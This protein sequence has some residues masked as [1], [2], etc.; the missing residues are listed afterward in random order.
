[1]RTVLRLLLWITA[2]VV[3]IVATG[4]WWFVYRPLPQLDGSAVVPGLHGEVTVERD[5]WGVPHIRA[6]S[7]EDL[8]EAQG[9]VLAQDRLWQMDLL[10]RAAR[11]QLS[12]V[13][14]PATLRIDKDFRLLNFSRAA[15]RDFGMVSPEVRRVMEAYARGVNLY[16]EEHTTR[17]PIEFT[18][19]NYKP[20]PWQPTDSLVIACYMYRTLTDTREEEMG[21]AIV[22]AKVGPELAKDLYSPEASMDHFVVGEANAGKDPHAAV[23]SKR[24]QDDDDEEMDPEDVLKASKESETVAPD[25]TAALGEEVKDWL[26]ESQ[27][28]IRHSLGSNNW[29]V[30]GEHTATGKPILAND[31][32]LEL[33]LPPIWYEVHLTAPDWNVKGFALP[34]APM[35]VVGHND[36]IAWGFTNNGADVLDLYIETFNPENPDEYRVN[37]AWKKADVYDEVIKVKGAADEHLK[38]VVTR[39]GP[40]VHQDGDKSYAM[41]WTVLEPGALCNFYNW[42][43]KAQNWGEFRETMKGIWGPGQNVVYA[44][45]DGN[46]GYVL[47]AHVP[48]RKKGHGEVPVPGDTDDYEWTGYIPFDQLPQAF[49][50]ESGLIVTANARVTGPNYKPYITD[51]WEEPYRTARIYD[52]LHDKRDLRPEDMLKIQVDTY[53]YP[54][55]FLGEQLVA[56]AKL[57][58]PK[59]ERAR[60]LI[61]QAKDWNGMAD[62]NSPVVSF[63]DAALFRALDLI[64]EPQLG[65]DTEDY[66]W[67][68]VAFLQRV[69]TERPARWLPADYKNY[70]ELLSAA[71]DQAVKRLEQKTK[72][73]DPDDWAWKRFNYLD[74][75][76]PIGRDG[77][78]KRLLSI[79][80]QPQ[81]GTEWSPRAASRHHGPSERFVANLADWDESIMLITGGES[82]QTGS[83]HYRDQFPYWFDGK[84][85]YEPFSDAAEAKARRH[86]LTLKPGS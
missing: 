81:S 12:E 35:V 68:R 42:L 78:L 13:L 65:K 26:E 29:V 73:A 9:Y 45:V 66:H 19:L 17:L 38:L 27:R 56:A 69:L 74:M 79:T 1:M 10:R 50:P 24:D 51:H 53:S 30:N 85:I 67:R 7:V 21:R 43:G 55:L 77:I 70:D 28:Q 71:A 61:Q 33:T 25:L 4:I 47:G 3:V 5:N 75:F 31:M 59:D 60:K 52:L 34:G 14:G 40:V 22:T 6:A 54:H 44:D 8:A 63:L 18:L 48:I 64:L 72:D 76:N 49:N 62:A 86:T 2:I 37:G 20:K 58:P 57:T 84:A 32:H 41:R 16:I 15:E 83:E 36:R 23:K 82:G 80:D 46:I 39:H 11:G